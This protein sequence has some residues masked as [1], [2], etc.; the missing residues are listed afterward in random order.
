M[1]GT[2][3]LVAAVNELK[4]QVADSAALMD[5]NFQKLMDA[6]NNAQIPPAE[7]A[8]ID[9]AA[10]DIRAQIQSMKDTATKD[11]PSP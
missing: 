7:Q 5:M 10:A 3:D 11:T 1:Q 4:T 9:Q 2:S 8:I 6:L